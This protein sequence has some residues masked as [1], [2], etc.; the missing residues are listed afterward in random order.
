MTPSDMTID[1][2]VISLLHLYSDFWYN[3]LVSTCT[4]HYLLVGTNMP[5]SA[6]PSK[7]QFIG[8]PIMLHCECHYLFIRSAVEVV[9]HLM[10]RLFDKLSNRSGPTLISR[11]QGIQIIKILCCCFWRELHH[12]HGLVIYPRDPAPSGIM[13]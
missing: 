3:S 11:R 7:F 5:Q 10:E 8:S 2:K 6:S 4:C 9:E 12:R 1:Y 13:P